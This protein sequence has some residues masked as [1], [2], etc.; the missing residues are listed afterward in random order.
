MPLVLILVVYCLGLTLSAIPVL[1]AKKVASWVAV[2]WY[3]AVTMVFFAIVMCASL[4]EGEHWRHMW[5]FYGLVWGFNA[6]KFGAASL[7]RPVAPAEAGPQV[8]RV[9]GLARAGEG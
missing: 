6:A 9:R 4:H 1:G 2:S 8:F 5:L 3:L 7:V